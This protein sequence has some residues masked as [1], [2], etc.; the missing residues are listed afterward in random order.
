MKRSSLFCAGLWPFIVLPLLLLLVLLFFRWHPIEQTVA[1]NAT[2]KLAEGGQDWAKV[3]T[4]NRGREVLITGTPPD[5]QSIDRARELAKG[6]YG[7]RSVEISPSVLVPVAPPE[8]PKFE[9]IATN[10][11]VV[12]NG[13]L[14][15]QD[16]VENLVAQ[17]HTAYGAQNVVNNLSVGK[18][19]NPLPDLSGFF[20]GLANSTG[21]SEKLT[22]KLEEGKLTLLGEV[23]S[24]G[25]KTAMGEQMKRFFGDNI[26]NQLTVLPAPVLIPTVVKREDCQV[27]I[28]TLLSEGK[29]NFASGKATIDQLSYPLLE[30][31]AD[32]AK[33]CPDA[34]FEVAGHTDSAGSLEL[35]LRLS[36]ARAQA[37]TDYLIKLGLDNN[38]F[39]SKGYGPNQP[40]ADNST[41]EGRAQNRRIEFTLTN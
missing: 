15:S 30:S 32:A 12:L 5:Q 26:D 31:I 13:V 7:V 27:K 16:S 36:E 28:N 37:V 18:N 25:F 24:I 40:I 11:S 17:A 6:A 19:T 41:E 34:I 10:S 23:Q 33:R 4:F 14:D 1:Q 8:N 38:Q 39:A 9:A 21:D 35:N 20:K 2:N 3:E 29:I 22:T